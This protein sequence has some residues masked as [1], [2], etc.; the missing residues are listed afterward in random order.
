MSINIYNTDNLPVPV[1]IIVERRNYSR[2]ALGKNEIIV[3]LP[4]HFS[5]ADKEKTLKQFLTWARK[6]INEKKFYSVYQNTTDYYRERKLKV[7]NTEFTIQL[8][9]I[10]EGRNHLSYRGD[11]IL[12]IYLLESQEQRKQVTEIQR[13]LL[14]F[15]EKYFLKTIQQRTIYWNDLYFKERIDKITIKH[16][17]SCWGSCTVKRA[18]HFSTKLL[19]MPES[20]I[21]YVIVHELAHLKEMNHSLRFWKHVENAMPDYDIHRK[22]LQQHGNRIDF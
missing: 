1:K 11:N 3:R 19:L 2:V 7:Y 14:R 17:I 6:Q 8:E 22:W 13:F 10:Q 21:D 15:T 9:M 4:R 12:K 16:T 20:V 5:I 18:I